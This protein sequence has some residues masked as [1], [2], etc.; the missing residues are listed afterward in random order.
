MEVSGPRH[1]LAAV[2]RKRTAI[3]GWVGPRTGLDVSEKRKI[4]C[5]CRVSNQRLRVKHET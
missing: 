1:A 2:S 4:S 3:G 5:A